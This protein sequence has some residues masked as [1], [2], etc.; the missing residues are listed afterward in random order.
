[1]RTTFLAFFIVATVAFTTIADEPKITG[2]TTNT[3]DF[4]GA[5]KRNQT[6][7]LH[8]GKLYVFG[9]TKSLDPRD[10]DPKNFCDEG[11]V[12][13]LATTKVTA[14]KKPPVPMMRGN[15]IVVN[16]M[17]YAIGGQTHDGAKMRVSDD[18]WKYDF[19]KDQWTKLDARLPSA[20]T[21]F[22]IA[23]KDGVIWVFGGWMADPR[24]KGPKGPGL[25]V[26]DQIVT[27]DLTK[28][29][30][31][32]AIRAE[33]L[34][35][36]RRSYPFAATNG[37][38]FVCGGLDDT[39]AYV[40]TAEVYDLETN[41]WN[42]MPAPIDARAMAEMVEVEGN[43]YLAG[44]FSLGKAA[45]EKPNPF[46]ENK[47][48]EVYDAKKKTWTK[49]IE[50]LPRTAGGSALNL[51]ANEGKVVIWSIDQAKANTAYLTTI[52]PTKLTK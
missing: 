13:D 16:A 6:V 17:G 39:F 21:L 48:L 49:P 47:S 33:K 4:S 43:L 29:K 34:S 38:L 3:I 23:Q 50:I 10:F 20:R 1:M 28:S 18:I 51:F 24:A 19:A 46:A 45:A 52:D 12:I 2:L 36:Q 7:F 26:T 30:P 32:V 44:G 9:G 22:G 5:A 35:T 37:K 41:K 11:F 15:T 40:K 27:I 31:Q 42:D 8:D 14:L 25:K